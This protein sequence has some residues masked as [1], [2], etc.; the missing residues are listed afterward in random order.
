M[1]RVMVF[2]KCYISGCNISCFLNIAGFKT[3]FIQTTSRSTILAHRQV[4]GFSKGRNKPSCSINNP[5]EHE[6]DMPSSPQVISYLL[7]KAILYDQLLNCPS[8]EPVLHR[9][10]PVHTQLNININIFSYN[11]SVL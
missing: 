3:S 2:Q 4:A 1:L 10:T 8:L 11:N 7:Q 6:S 5:I 9:L